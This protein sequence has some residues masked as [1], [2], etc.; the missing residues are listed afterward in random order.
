MA[1]KIRKKKK[2]KKKINNEKH[3]KIQRHQ[4]RSKKEECG[5][6]KENIFINK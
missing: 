2:K 5:V 6:K 3:F 4:K 1:N